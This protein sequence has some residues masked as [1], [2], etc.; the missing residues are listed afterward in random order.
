[1]PFLQTSTSVRVSLLPV[2]NVLLLFLTLLPAAHLRANTAGI[3]AQQLPAL[4]VQVDETYEYHANGSFG[5][6][7][8]Q[9]VFDALLTD[10]SALPSWISIGENSGTFTFRAKSTERG[11]ILHIRLIVLNK[12]GKRQEGTFYVLVDMAGDECSVDA[13][14]DRLAKL[15]PCKGKNVRLRGKTESGRYIWYGPNDF[16][17]T[18]AEPEVELPG[19][20]YLDDP[21]GCGHRSIVEVRDDKDACTGGTD[22]NKLPG[23]SITADRSKGDTPLV[24]NLEGSQS[25]DAEGKIIEY[26]WDWKGGSAAGP[27]PTATFTKQGTYEV[28]LTVTDDTGAR[29]TDRLTVSAGGEAFVAAHY[30]LEAECATVGSNWK[31]DKSLSSS[32][33]GFVYSSRNSISSPPSDRSSNQVRFKVTA[34]E[35]GLYN[36]HAR[37]DVNGRQTG[38]F[39]VR[40]NG[41]E[42]TDWYKGIG[43]NQGFRWAPFTEEIRLRAGENTI[44][45]AF[46]ETDIY[47]DKV[48]VTN[49]TNTP[50]GQGG[51]ANNCGTGD[52]APDTDA[53]TPEAPTAAGDDELWLEAECAQIGSRWMKSTSS[54]ASGGSFVVLANGNSMSS[55][56]QDDASNRVRFT[57]NVEGGGYTLF[58]RIAAASNQDDSFWVRANGGQWHKWS[59]GVITGSGFSWNEFHTVLQLPAGQNTVDFAYRED[60]TKLDKIFLTNT[61]TT[62]SGTGGNASNCGGTIA[63]PAAPSPGNP[64]S[65]LPTFAFEAECGV[66][67]DKWAD[68][69]NGAASNKRYVYFDGNSSQNKGSDEDALIYRVDLTK[70]GTYHLFLRMNG[71]DGGRNSF[72]VRVDNEEWKEMWQEADG[73]SLTTN[74]FEWRKANDDGKALSFDLS[75][76]THFI[77][78]AVREA[79]TGL[80]KVLLS[81]DAELPTGYGPEA[82]S[83]GKKTSQTITGVSFATTTDAQD[84]ESTDDYLEEAS[85]EV[86][87]NP[88]DGYVNLSLSSD[89]DGRVDVIVTDATGRRV[90]QLTFDK[91]G[92]NL[93][94]ELEVSDLPPG[95]YY[96]RILEADR[97]QVKP[98]VKR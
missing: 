83:C 31:S 26:R 65:T 87:P 93:T 47:L 14:A 78:V 67:S 89:Y 33:N 17:S 90:R 40:V 49:T 9:L 55:A 45:Y 52:P 1:M 46:R 58:A 12:K 51:E 41:G 18:R 19:I 23:A 8:D 34:L 66:N 74:G 54:S 97:Q 73:S 80:D 77:K 29:S 95:M 85:L 75:P 81:P 98:F 60:G 25:S 28:T 5:E 69:D 57:F 38:S 68:T 16:Y 64:E 61:Y 36:M 86:Y 4:T 76:G 21:D 35:A 7:A 42:W 32:G 96:L 91:A 84:E 37:I 30:W 15:L 44:D 59:D 48:Y 63:P 3:E 20:Y 10:G 11:K 88:V 39:W 50:S 13:N 79:G 71:F 2:L 53:S 82:A 70:G 92:S 62:P 43:P 6:R 22:R 56:P 94:A 27:T 24:V 72:W